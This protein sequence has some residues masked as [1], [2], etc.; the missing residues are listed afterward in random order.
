MRQSSEFL[1][2]I[3]SHLDLEEQYMFANNVE[4]VKIYC[5][6]CYLL[7][8]HNFVDAHDDVTFELAIEGRMFSGAIYS[9]FS[10]TDTRMLTECL[11]KHLS[12][13]RTVRYI[14]SYISI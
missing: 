14:G 4:I 6:T 8:V 11:N 13:H 1:S 3:A 12:T 9:I 10:E 5:R 2:L 7:L